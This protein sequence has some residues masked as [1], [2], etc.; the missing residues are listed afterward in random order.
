MAA[1]SG[2][3]LC[4]SRYTGHRP[5]VALDHPEPGPNKSDAEEAHGQADASQ[6]RG[7]AASVESTSPA[8]VDNSMVE[9]SIRH[10][11]H[12]MTNVEP[13]VESML[14]VDS[15]WKTRL[16]AQR[17]ASHANRQGGMQRCKLCRLMVPCAQ[18]LVP[19]CGH[20]LA[21]PSPV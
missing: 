12:S 10:R 4:L 5:P 16:E 14:S 11:L 15:V 17:K 3:G 18:S 20:A 6:Q 21:P 2:M 9:T 19:H 7:S 1:D 8:I 13:L